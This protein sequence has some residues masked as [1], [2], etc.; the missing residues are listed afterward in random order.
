MLQTTIDPEALKSFMEKAIAADR[1]EMKNIASGLKKIAEDAGSGDE[2]AEHIQAQVIATFEEVDGV[3][4]EA[5]DIVLTDP[6]R[7]VEVCQE[8]HFRLDK[9]A[10][11]LKKFGFSWDHF[12]P[13]VLK[14]RDSYIEVAQRHID[15]V[16]ELINNPAQADNE[17]L[18][19]LAKKALDYCHQAIAKLERLPNENNP[20]L[21]V[22]AFLAL[23]NCTIALNEAYTY[24]K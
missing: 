9:Q 7:A 17:P 14:D 11:Y 1:D 15:T 23:D 19:K 24:R 18:Q 22:E 3:F 21:G 6:S 4:D 8:A 16:E 2:Q 20:F 10:E 5:L 12:A 13:P